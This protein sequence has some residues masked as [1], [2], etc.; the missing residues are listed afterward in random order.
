MNTP[1]TSCA[2][3]PS[4]TIHMKT[5]FTYLS[6][7]KG[8]MIRNGEKNHCHPF[9]STHVRT[10]THTTIHT[11]TGS[12][13]KSYWCF[14]IPPQSV[15]NKEQ[16]YFLWWQLIT[17]SI[18]TKPYPYYKHEKQGTITVLQVPPHNC[19]CHGKVVCGA[20]V[21]ACVCVCVSV[22][23]CTCACIPLCVCV[24]MRTRVWVWVCVHACVCV[25]L[26]WFCL[27]SVSEELIK[28]IQWDIIKIYIGLQVK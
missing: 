10:R 1:T 9:K 12:Q 18:F 25:C 5:H 17:D 19:C 8:L 14:E 16:W 6:S 23:V 3:T 28:R 21:R 15:L 26:F 20:C 2:S 11:N 27:Q 13:T 24:C 7:H 22:C 4:G